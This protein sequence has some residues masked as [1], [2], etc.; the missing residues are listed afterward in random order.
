VSQSP[1]K[2]GEY[3]P[4]TRKERNRN[5]EEAEREGEPSSHQKASVPRIRKQVSEKCEREAERPSR[6]RHDRFVVGIGGVRLGLNQP[7]SVLVPNLQAALASQSRASPL[8]RLSLWQNESNRRIE[9]GTKASRK[10]CALVIWT[11]CGP[12]AIFRPSRDLACDQKPGL[13]LHF[14]LERAT[15]F[16]L[17]TL[18]LAKFPM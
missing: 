15:R 2:L 1:V 4:L 7:S 17:A 12:G 5:D 9:T 8:G 16:E 11:K 6:Q 14:C 13:E 3:Y 10:H 18:T